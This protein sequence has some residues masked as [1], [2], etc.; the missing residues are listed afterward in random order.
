MT[1]KKPHGSAGPDPESINPHYSHRGARVAPHPKQ[2]DP[3]TWDREEMRALLR[4]HDFPRVFQQL[5]KI[6]YS[7]LHIGRLTGQTQ[8]EISAIIHGRRPISYYLIRRIVRGLGIPPGHAGVSWCDCDTTTTAPGDPPEETS[9]A[10]DPQS[11]AD[12]WELAQRIDR[13]VEAAH[14]PD[15]CQHRPSTNNDNPA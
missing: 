14:L 2:P 12:T 8:P 4:R 1:R 5:Q 15:C 3:A 11:I 6:G 9:P 10:P 7:Q 13:L